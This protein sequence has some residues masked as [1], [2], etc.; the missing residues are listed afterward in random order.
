M[1]IT[2]FFSIRLSSAGDPA[3]LSFL[4]NWI[5]THLQD[6]Q[7][8]LRKPLL[9]AEFGKSWK[10]PGYSPY[11]RDNLFNTVYSKIYSSARSGGAAAGG[12]FWQLFTEGM[13]NYR[14]GYEIILRENTSTGNLITQ[15]SRKLYHIRRM[16]VR[17]KNIEKIKRAR[18]MRRGQ[19][20]KGKRNG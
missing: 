18:A 15:Q 3:Q 2:G 20:V 4:N 9:F 7:N 17:L 14:D 10:D 6:A 8:I 1:A 13:D 5:D 11:Q 16:Y 19:W 12:I